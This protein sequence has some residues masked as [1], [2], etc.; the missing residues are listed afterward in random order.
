MAQTVILEKRVLSFTFHDSLGAWSSNSNPALFV[1][2]VGVEYSVY[3]DG[4]SYSCIGFTSAAIPDNHLLGN[5][6]PAGGADNG[7]PFLMSATSDGSGMS[8]MT[9]DQGDTHEVG[10]YKVEENAE[11]PSADVKIKGYSGSYL[12]Y[13]KVPKVWL[14][15]PEST[16][17]NPVLVPFTY[18]EALDNV[19]ITPDFSAGNQKITLPEGYMARSAVVKKPATL[20]PANIKAGEQIAGIIGEYDGEVPETEEKTVAAD[21]S[22]GDM[23]LEPTEGKYLSKATVTKPDTLIPENIADGV[24]VAGI[25]GTLKSGGGDGERS[26]DKK[27]I[28]FFDP[29]GNVIY[30][31]TRSEIRQMDQLPPGPPLN[32]CT[33]AKWTHTLDE[34]KEE[35]YFADVGPIYKVGSTQATVLIIETSAAS[36]TVNIAIGSTGTTYKIDWGDGSSS[37]YGSTSS[38]WQYAQRS[39]TYTTAGQYVIKLT[40]NSTSGRYTLGYTQSNVYYNILGEA[41]SSASYKLESP[42]YTFNYSLISVLV[43]EPASTISPDSI[44]YAFNLIRLKFICLGYQ[45]SITGNLFKNCFRITAIAGKPRKGISGSGLH[46]NF[47]LKRIGTTTFFYTPQYGLD[48]M[49]EVIYGETSTVYFGNTKWQMLMTGETPPAVSSSITWGTKPIYV[50]DTAVEAYKTASGWSNVASYILPASMY[51]D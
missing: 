22:G 7:I 33:F 13:E 43:C 14:A 21:F 1:P 51:P 3:W 40:R 24:D 45:D 12:N 44:N 47:S 46:T 41:Q 6:L 11:P 48:S 2:E 5:P 23:I 4:N 19:E 8:I 16:E 36:Q 38:T 18:G 9:F 32:G 28:R 35:T 37:T 31:Y 26:P 10:I 42:P 17:D 50:P 30:G 20:T 29:L 27:P 39:H 25:K 15:A 34:L 49:E